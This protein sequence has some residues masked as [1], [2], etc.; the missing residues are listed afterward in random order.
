MSTTMDETRTQQGGTLELRESMSLSE[1][2]LQPDGTV[3]LDLIRPCVGRGKG[4]HL[5]E[6]NMLERDAGVF[7]GWKMY[8]DHQ[9]DQAR[10]AAGGLP[11]S[12]RDLGGRIIESWWDPNVPADEARGFGQGAVR[13]R[14][15]PTPFV[16]DLV[17]HDPEIVE[18]SINASATGVRPTTRNGKRVW[19][20][21]GIR[22][23]PGTV[24][25]VTEAG[26]GGRV[27]HIMEASYTSP[28]EEEAALLDTMTDSELQGYL[29][30]QRPGLLESLDS[31]DGDGDAQEGTMEITPELLS[32]ALDSDEGRR[33]ILSVVHEYAQDEIA[34]IVEA[35]VTDERDLL[36]AEA[37]ADADR[38]IMLRDLRDH[39]H[40][41]IEAA[42]L[43]ERFASQSK[44]KFDLT[45]NGPTASLDVIP[46]I[47][48]DGNVTKSERDLLTEAVQDEIGAQR[49]LIA[50]V[51]PTRVSGQGSGAS[52]D[53]GE[54][55][56]SKLGP[57]TS[58]LL[59]ESGFNDP[60]KVYVTG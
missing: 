21:E 7:V 12:L 60:D 26:A 30:E 40:G 11:R 51:R 25:W 38:Q 16:R 34:A 10:R 46:E 27:A 47:D 22:P 33:M 28:E 31:G 41:L 52:G 44:S 14:S 49:D 36:R 54:K 39:A 1:S 15:R 57:L 29:R 4:E 56:E 20:V 23:R 43:P 3:V 37:R 6:A 45:E 42:K 17:E 53:G 48:D 35:A 59:Q 13:G 55:S 9:S 2:A 24:D 19:L 32:E 8:V 5:Y 58:S 50:A 18:L